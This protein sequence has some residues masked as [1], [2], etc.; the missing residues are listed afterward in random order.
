MADSMHGDYE[1]DV[2]NY[3]TLATTGDYNLTQSTATELLQ[4]LYGTY[5]ANITF[6]STISIKNNKSANITAYRQGTEIAVATVLFTDDTYTT[7]IP[8]GDYTTSV[9]F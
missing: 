9:D 6:H 5:T 2:K 3:L 4:N 7:K 8:D 1:P